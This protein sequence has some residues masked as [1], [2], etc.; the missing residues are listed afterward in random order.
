MKREW[1][2]WKSTFGVIILAGA[3]T[4]NQV[5]RADSNYRTSYF[6]DRSLPKRSPTER[7]I[8]RTELRKE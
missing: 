6:S 7:K 8:N 4:A 2:N 3:F 5:S 1:L